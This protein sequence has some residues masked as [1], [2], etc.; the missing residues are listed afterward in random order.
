[1]M[2]INGHNISVED[3]DPTVHTLD[4]G[5]FDA[6]MR[7]FEEKYRSD[8]RGGSGEF[9]EAYSNGRADPGNLDFEEWSFLCEHFLR[10]V[11]RPPGECDTFHVG[12][13]LI[14]GLSF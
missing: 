12:P 11:E 2:N 9:F 6:R 7:H 10:A 13:E 1:M 4:P 3:F 8:F 14:S 5:Y